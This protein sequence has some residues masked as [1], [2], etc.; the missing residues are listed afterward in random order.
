MIFAGSERNASR[1]TITIIIVPTAIFVML[2]ISFCVYFKVRRRPSKE[3]LEGKQEFGFVIYI[4][5]VRPRE[6]SLYFFKIK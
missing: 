1:S 6:L 5:I 4:Q 3:K 2:V